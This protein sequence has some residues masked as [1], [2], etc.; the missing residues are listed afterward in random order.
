MPE[1]KAINF[2]V[3]PSIGAQLDRLASMH[4]L[5]ATYIE[6]RGDRLSEDSTALA[7]RLFELWGIMQ[8]ASVL[9]GSVCQDK[10]QEALETYR[11]LFE[12]GLDHIYGKVLSKEEMEDLNDMLF[13]LKVAVIM[14]IAGCAG[15]S[16]VVKAP[17]EPSTGTSQ[18]QGGEGHGH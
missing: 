16:T 8:T 18:P 5:L 9:F 13:R 7:F 10:V 11:N 6:R 1:A 12:V 14:L 2:E 17:S 3:P 15:L 4:G